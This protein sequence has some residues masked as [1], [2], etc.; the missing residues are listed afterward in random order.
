MISDS[1]ESDS[2]FNSLR[3]V[4]I[5]KHCSIENSVRRLIHKLK[6]FN[7]WLN[8][9]ADRHLCYD[10]TLMHD[11]KSFTTSKLT[12]DANEKLIIVKNIGFITFNLNIRGKKM[13]NTLFN[14]EYAFDLN[15]H[16][17]STNILN[18]KDCFVITKNDKLIIIDLKNDAIFI[19]EI[20]QSETKRNFYV[21]NFW[22]FSI[23]K[24]NAI[25][26]IWK[27]WHRRLKHFNMQNVKKLVN[28]NLI[29]DN[30]NDSIEKCEVCIM[31]K[32][33]RKSNHQFVR[34]SRRANRPNQ[35]FHTNLADDE[36]IVLIFRDKRYAIIF[37]N[38]FSNY[39]WIYLVRKKNEFQKNFRDFIKIMLIRGLFVKAIRCDNVRKNIN[40]F[41]I[42]L[43]KNHDIQWE[44][45]TFENF[46]QNEV[47]ERAF[48][49][50]FNRVRF[51][52]YDSKFSKY[53]WNECVHTIIYLKN[54]SSCTLLKKKI[55][56]ETW[57]EKISDFSV[58]HF[59]EI[60]CFAKKKKI[61]KF[62][63]RVIKN[64]F[65][66]YEAF[67]Q[68]RVWN[69]KNRSVIRTVHVEFDDFTS[70]SEIEKNSDDFNYAT[71]DFSQTSEKDLIT[72]ETADISFFEVVGEAE[73]SMKIDND[74]IDQNV[75]SD[76]ESV[77]SKSRDENLVRNFADM[78]INQPSEQSDQSTSTF[79]STA[80][81][82]FSRNIFRSNYAKLND[83]D[84][85]FR[86][87]DDRKK[88]AVRKII[89]FSTQIDKTRGFAAKIKKIRT[90]VA[91]TYKISTFWNEIFAHSK[92]NKWIKTAEKK[93]NHHVTNQ[94]WII[95]IFDSG[96][97]ILSDKW[98]FDIKRESDDEITRYKIKWVAQDF[99]QIEKIDLSESYSK[100]V[101]S[102]LWKGVLALCTRYDYEVHHVDIISAYLK[103][104][105]KEK[106]WMQQFHDFESNDSN[107]TCLLKKVIDGLKQSIKMWYEIL[108]KNFINI[109]Y[110]K[111]FSDHS[112]FI[113]E[114]YV[115]IAVYVN[116]LLLIESKLS[117]VF[118][119]KNKLMTRFRVKNLKKVTFY[120]KIKIIR[121]RQNRK[122]K[123]SQTIFIK[124]LM[125]N[126]EFHKLKIR[127]IS[128]SMK[129]IDFTTEFNDQTYTAT[130]DEIHVYQVILE[131]LQW[132]II[133]TRQNITY[134][135]N[136][137]A[138]F[139]VNS[140]SLHMQ[141]MKRMICYLT[142][143]NE[144]CIRY[145]F[146]NENEENLVNYTDSAYDDD[147]TTRRFHFDYVF[148]LWNNPIF[149][150]FKR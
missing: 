129:C 40:D 63:E 21:L 84:H 44:F 7:F 80:S 123:F 104:E 121:N 68:Y 138:Q 90:S 75:E 145:D 113:H 86:D 139:S 119:F 146:S 34:I 141:A 88:N 109:D 96:A 53:L 33:H 137:L 36:K 41:N 148:E 48:R 111:L 16:M 19:I 11:I 140:T 144:L 4:R 97:R 27:N 12:E 105:L 126:C 3:S 99:R 95:K 62:H 1:D 78:K 8:S 31:K 147:V 120:L 2:F 94:T 149:H 125:K 135:T 64:R 6:N 79:Q 142:E 26:F 24:I 54:R 60:T 14:V 58:L 10:K 133:M 35:K 57:F 47:A 77:F 18:R 98:I 69:V 132:L 134:S 82:R 107:K 37:V 81:D 143:T 45:I 61:K 124:R 23:R 127:S 20:I 100:V 39:I 30:E 76:E 101:K 15:Y 50:I 9:A 112:V 66:D 29:S 87:R 46:H 118:D 28:M 49:I 71:L 25:I 17:I 32:M 13:K 52:L 72:H 108:K 65:L 83:S 43:L 150:S 70:F 59:F 117:D 67:N 5:I 55:S 102:M 106:I 110:V 114:N 93:Y 22:H 130:F 131:S 38:D 91:A 122:M 74:E 103:V 51:C 85:K 92:K 115:I 42:E 56:Y 73:K 128:I 136:K 89:K 116:D